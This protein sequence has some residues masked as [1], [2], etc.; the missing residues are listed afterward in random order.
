V[1][2]ETQT[3]FS[4]VFPSRRGDPLDHGFATAVLFSVFF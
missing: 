3:S 2:S 4:V 1:V